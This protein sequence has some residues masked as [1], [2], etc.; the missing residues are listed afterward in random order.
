MDFL[1][2]KVGKEFLERETR[3]LK[4][5]RK[6]RL[7]LAAL[8]QVAI[9]VRCRDGAGSDVE[10]SVQCPMSLRLCPLVGAESVT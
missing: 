5:L 3:R 10:A 1:N 8:K 7:L 6:V 9:T 4:L 2:E